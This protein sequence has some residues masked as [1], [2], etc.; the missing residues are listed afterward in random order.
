MLLIL[1]VKLYLATEHPFL[2]TE[3]SP[4]AKE[5]EYECKSGPYQWVG[6]EVIKD[7]PNIDVYEIA[8]GDT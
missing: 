1:I 2:V 6:V 8:C 3:L 5:Q 7:S 4:W